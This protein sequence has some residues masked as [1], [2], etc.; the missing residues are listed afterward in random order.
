MKFIRIRNPLRV[1]GRNLM[2][3]QICGKQEILP[4]QCP[5]CGKS[6]CTIHRLPENH[7]CMNMDFARRVK[8]EDII[9]SNGTKTYR[10]TINNN[11][12]QQKNH[13]YFGY[14]EIKHLALGSLLVASVGLS[15]GFEYGLEY[16]LGLALVLTASFFIH[17]LAHKIVAQKSGLWAEFRLTLWGSLLTAIFAILPG[18]F[19][20]ISPGAVMISGPA[21]TQD[22]GKISI[23]GPI[24]NIILAV[25]FLILWFFS[26]PYNWIFGIGAFINSYIALF[27]LLPFG[28]LDGF[29][30]FYWNK[31]IWLVSFCCSIILLILA[32][33][34]V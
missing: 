15:I 34:F 31:I 16:M 27:N 18:T 14:K 10:R 9:F 22:I 33:S 23:S 7:R 28:I 6:Y 5:Y 25:I 21:K 20:I 2:K 4:F 17:E 1:K 24:T 26:I 19:K 32:Y 13:V 3:C 29:K 12:Q 11:M 8:K 30:I